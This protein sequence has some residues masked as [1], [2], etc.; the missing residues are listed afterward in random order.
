MGLLIFV[1]ELGHFLTARLSGIRVLEFGFGFPP[2]LIGITRGGIVYSINLIPLGGFVRMLG[3]NGD[4]SEPDSFAAKPPSR[5]ALVLAAGSAMNF[6]TAVAIFALIAATGLPTP[7]DQVRIAEVFPGSP[8]LTAGLQPGDIVLSVAGEPVQTTEGLRAITNR[9]LGQEIGLVILRGNQQ[10]TI[11]LTPR[12]NPPQGEGPMGVRIEPVIVY[13]PRPLWEAIPY[14]FARSVEMLGIFVYG[15]G[16]MVRGIVAP[17][18]AGPIGIA[19]LTG[20][21][22]RVGGLIPL[23]NL[24]ALLSLNLFA[25]NLLP[26]P[27]LDGGRLLF[28]LIEMVRGKRVAPEREGRIHFVGIVFLISLAVIISYFDILRIASGRSIVP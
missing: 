1:H 20:E 26:L 22:A 24:A 14:G 7:S 25:I 9:H 27:A 28:V 16:A 23:A 18:V 5:R 12:P 13:V 10:L 11:Y 15:I 2:R 3:E 21:V 8:A 4:S 19:Q 6:L 17:D